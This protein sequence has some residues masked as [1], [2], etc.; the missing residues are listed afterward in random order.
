METEIIRS[1]AGDEEL[2]SQLAEECAELAQAALKLRRAMDGRN[3]T[4][5]TREECL[6]KLTEEVEDVL[7]VLDVLHTVQSTEVQEIQRR[8]LDRWY[9][10]LMESRYKGGVQGWTKETNS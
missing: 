5:K 9:K 8:K 7:L 4:S 6:D 10:R 2:L 1:L 3:P